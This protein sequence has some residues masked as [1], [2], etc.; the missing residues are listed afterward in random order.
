VKITFPNS[1]GPR[2]S[3]LMRIEKPINRSTVTCSNRKS[4]VS[5]AFLHSL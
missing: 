2:G 4:P 3:R 1:D 5:Q